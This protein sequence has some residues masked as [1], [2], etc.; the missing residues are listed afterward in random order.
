V[1]LH[2][3]LTA[4]EPLSL[5]ISGP[6]Q[7]ILFVTNPVHKSTDFRMRQHDTATAALLKE[8]NGST[9]RLITTRTD[10]QIITC[11]VNKDKWVINVANLKQRNAMIVFDGRKKPVQVLEPHA[12]R[13]YA[14]PLLAPYANKKLE[15]DVSGSNFFDSIAHI[16]FVPFRDYSQKII[17][18]TTIPIYSARRI[19]CDGKYTLSIF[20]KADDSQPSGIIQEE[21]QHGLLRNSNNTSAGNNYYQQYFYNPDRLI[22]S[23]QY[24]QNSSLQYTFYY[25]YLPNSVIQYSS[26]YKDATIY[27]LDH[28]FRVIESQNRHFVY[29]RNNRTQYRYNTAGQLI[30]EQQWDKNQ[31]EDRITYSYTDLNSDDFADRKTYDSYGNLKFELKCYSQN[32][33]QVQEIYI[34]GALQSKSILTVSE[35][36][37]MRSS[38]YDK[39]GKLTSKF[40]RKKSPSY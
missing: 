34:E 38:T 32:G 18:Q 36:C 21:Y 4:Q 10:A 25:R 37:E 15:V 40:I 19:K 28:N 26:E 31:K 8:A 24:F 35:D 20:S 16:A 12:Y 30:E 33:D 1:S 7:A 11:I 5:T 14:Q 17:Q 3:N 27:L 6:S 23:I 9:S 22:D 2:G 13:Q 29:D 39:D